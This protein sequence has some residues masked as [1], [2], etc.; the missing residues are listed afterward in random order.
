LEITDEERVE[1]DLLLER[2]TAPDLALALVRM[3][4]HSAKIALVLSETLSANVNLVN[5]LGVLLA[6]TRIV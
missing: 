6:N 2:L 3:R 4:S 5:D 1:I